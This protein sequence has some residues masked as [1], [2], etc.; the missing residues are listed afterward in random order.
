LSQS[1]GHEEDVPEH[2]V[3]GREVADQILAA[4]QCGVDEIPKTASEKSQERFLQDRFADEAAPIF[5]RHQ[6]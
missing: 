5:H 3:G 2:Q 4:G 1:V 6:L